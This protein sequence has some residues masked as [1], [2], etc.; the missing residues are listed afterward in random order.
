MSAE[1]ERPID[2][3]VSADATTEP[4]EPTD[5]SAKTA[6]PAQPAPVARGRQIG[7]LAAAAVVAF[8]VDLVSKLLAVAQ[9]TDRA[10]IRLIPGVL[11][12]QL[13]RNPGAAFGLAGGGTIIFTLVAGAVV[14]FILTTARRLRSRGWAVALGLLLG[15]ALGN[16]GDR[17]FRDPGPLRGHVVDWIHLAH[18]PIFNVA[19]TC[20]V[21]GGLFAVLLSMRGK[22]LDGEV[23]V[24]PRTP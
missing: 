7:L 18:W 11:D 3:P 24:V 19:D 22:R 6:A 14:V 13:I 5:E 1:P 15:G 16:L 23:E 20:I 21:V 4:T 8:V 12:L 17:L 2:R 10:P 9:L